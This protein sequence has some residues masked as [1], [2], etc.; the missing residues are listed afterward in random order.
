MDLSGIAQLRP[1]ICEECTISCRDKQGAFTGLIAVL[2][3]D[4]AAVK[5][6]LL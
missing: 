2:L 3:L 4:A 6:P 5:S 1:A